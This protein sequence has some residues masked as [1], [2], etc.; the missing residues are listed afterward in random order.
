MYRNSFW[1][2]F[3]I[4]TEINNLIKIFILEFYLEYI[5]TE[6]KEKSKKWMCKPNML[7]QD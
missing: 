4:P 7:I 6:N 1:E 3:Q 5:V 2:G